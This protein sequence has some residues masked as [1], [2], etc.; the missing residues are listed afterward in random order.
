MQKAILEKLSAEKNNPC[1]TISMKTHRT[2]PD[3]A[4][5][6]I[7]LKQLVNETKKRLINKFGKKDTVGL[8]KKLNNIA[9]EYDPK[10]NLDSLHIFLSNTT[11]EIVKSPWTIDHNS[12]QISNTFA[13]K[14]LIKA[15]N[16][17]DAYLILVL[18]QSGVHLFYTINDTIINEI[19]NDDFPFPPNP[20]ILENKKEKSNAKL[21]DRMVS[22]YFHTV[23]KALG[24]IYNLNHLHCIVVCTDDN[25]SKLIHLSINPSIFYGN[26]KINYKDTTLNTIVKDAWVLN[27]ERQKSRIIDSINEMIDADN[28]NN[29]MIDLT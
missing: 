16:R 20:H 4:I 24:H 13:I 9:F 1:I 12:V 8:F 23:D 27:K 19:K 2:H 7:E 17:T 26:V 3:N 10:Y 25:Y 21:V 15:L 18:S 6:V 29:V 5:D 22:E 11:N 28:Q 14:P